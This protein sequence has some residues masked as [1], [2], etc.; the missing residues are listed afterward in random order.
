MPVGPPSTQLET[1][2]PA[3]LRVQVGTPVG[4]GNGPCGSVPVTTAVNIRLVPGTAVVGL[5]AVNVTVGVF[6]TTVTELEED[7]VATAL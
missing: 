3:P 5:V 7:V 6:L 1:L 4:V 2:P